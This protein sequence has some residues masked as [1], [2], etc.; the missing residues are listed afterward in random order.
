MRK[1]SFQD[2]DKGSS[3]L[4]TSMSEETGSL[5]VMR[6]EE[7]KEN[8]EKFDAFATVDSTR[9]RY[10]LMNNFFRDSV[11]FN[12]KIVFQNV[13]K[14]RVKEALKSGDYEKV[15]QSKKV[16]IESE[17]IDEDIAEA[18]I[19]VCIIEESCNE[20]L[21][22][23]LSSSPNA[24]YHAFNEGIR[25]YSSHEDNIA[26]M[27]PMD[28]SKFIAA[29]SEHRPSSFDPSLC[30]KKETLVKLGM[31]KT[32]EEFLKAADKC[33]ILDFFL[34]VEHFDEVMKVFAFN[35]GAK[36]YI[37][38]KVASESN[39]L[40]SLES[41]R[42]LR[43]VNHY[44]VLFTALTFSIVYTTNP[45]LF[46]IVAVILVSLISFLNKYTVTRPIYKRIFYFPHVL[47]LWKVDF[48]PSIG[49]LTAFLLILAMF[50]QLERKV[51]KSLL[52]EEG[53]RLPFKTWNAV[54]L[55][56]ILANLFL[57]CILLKH[58]VK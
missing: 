32:A 39:Q 28:L 43:S 38:H 19:V 41:S 55:T 25:Y 50:T 44:A 26:Y 33:G 8:V 14:A 40:K 23:L 49:T 10:E 56:S 2:I 12:T 4:I 13:F 42:W 15:R 6:A 11:A 22:K 52:R 31:S 3:D 58:G 54:S 36:D 20:E 21:A 47:I 53:R 37:I 9:E 16:F 5:S 18:T 24:Y 17:V 30:M 29:L 46:L 27:S 34:E 1:F 45:R 48:S 7:I 57:T 51:V 35:R